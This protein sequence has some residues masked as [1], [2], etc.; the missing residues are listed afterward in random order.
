MSML[1]LPV[2]LHGFAG[3]CVCVQWVCGCMCMCAMG[4]RVYVYVWMRVIIFQ[5]ERCIHSKVQIDLCVC[6]YMSVCT[7]R[8]S[9]QYVSMCVY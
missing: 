9:R 4:L 8:Y 7:Y 1:Y 5:C 3:V 2:G 6:M